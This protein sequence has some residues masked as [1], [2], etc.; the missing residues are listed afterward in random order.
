[1]VGVVAG[2]S[3]DDALGVSPIRRRLVTLVSSLL[4]QE[5]DHAQRL[6]SAKVRF[7]GP[8]VPFA[9]SLA[10]ELDTW[11]CTP[12]SA[13]NQP[14]FAAHLSRWLQA[15]NLGTGDLTDPVIERLLVARRTRYTNYSSRRSLRPM[16]GYL[17]RV[18]AA[19]PEL[20]ALP[21][22]AADPVLTRFCRH[23]LVERP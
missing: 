15:E 13:I 18:G 9:S 17:R 4:E 22:A 20:P 23:L 12:L 16:L 3:G 11:G 7:T 6:R 8:L 5:R 1:V 19:P 21:P 14:Q 2:R 10:T